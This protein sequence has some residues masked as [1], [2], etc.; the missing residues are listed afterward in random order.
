MFIAREEACGATEEQ[1]IGII[2][3]QQQTFCNKLVIVNASLP[4]QCF[5]GEDFQI[6]NILQAILVFPSYHKLGAVL[7]ILCIYVV[8]M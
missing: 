1:T 8:F 3:N 7:L 6:S 5:E 2:I 4:A